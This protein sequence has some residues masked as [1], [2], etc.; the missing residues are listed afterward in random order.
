MQ[1]VLEMLN[2][3]LV[4][5][6]AATIGLKECLAILFSKDFGTQLVCA[7]LIKQGLGP[8]GQVKLS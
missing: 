7:G 3:S 2:P 5:V 4:A 8:L 1:V 6:M